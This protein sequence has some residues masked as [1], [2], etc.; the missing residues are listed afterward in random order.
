[1]HMTNDK[2]AKSIKLGLIGDNI[3]ASQ[4]P[5]LHRLAG[6]LNNCIVT[7]DLLIPKEQGIEFD[8]LFQ[9]CIAE[10]YHG[11]NITYPYKE[12]VTGMVSIEDKVVKSLGAANTVLLAGESP[13]GFNTD[14]SGFIAAYR[15]QRKSRLPGSVGMVGTG[16]VG[17][18]VAFGLLT[19]GA[20]EIRLLDQQRDKAER[21][22]DDLRRANPDCTILVAETLEGC[23]GLVNCTPVGMVGYPGTP[24]PAGHIGGAQW[25]FDA[26]YTPVETEFLAHAAS[27]GLEIISGYELFF[28]QGIDAWKFFSGLPVDKAELRKRLSQPEP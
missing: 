26:V 19:L 6:A 20:K 21:L 11:L 7:Y 27:A 28:W 16:G 10:G 14:Y 17:R 12:R 9:R 4:S 13:R 22:A 1:M 8:A 2:Q 25:A 23:D 5:K 24:I 18:A 15:Q 3:R